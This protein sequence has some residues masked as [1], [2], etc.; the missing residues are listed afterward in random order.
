MWPGDN[1][2]FLLRSGIVSSELADR[3]IANSDLSNF[4]MSR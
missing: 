2:L 1:D 4:D 3:T